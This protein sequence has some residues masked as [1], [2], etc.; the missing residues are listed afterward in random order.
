MIYTYR[1]R[2][3]QLPL[4]LKYG[5]GELTFQK[6]MLPPSRKSKAVELLKKY[7][8]DFI[9]VGTGTNRFIAKY[10][11]FAMKVAL[12]NDGI[13][14]NKQEYAISEQLNHIFPTSAADALELSN[15]GHILMSDYCPAFTSYQEMYD[16]HSRIEQILE[17]WSNAG[18]LLGDV[19]ISRINYANWGL[20]GDK[21]ICID[22][23]YVIP[24]SLYTFRCICGESDIA[25]TDNTF[26]AYK[27]LSCGRIIEDS[28]LRKRISPEIRMKMLENA[29]KGSIL[30]TGPTL[31]KEIPDDVI[32]KP[33]GPDDPDY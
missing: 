18:F 33:L 17:A 7:N 10:D 14:D 32:A 12:D 11:N 2:L 9:D 16:H 22:Y 28:L 24:A 5:L 20:K 19:G 3:N 1:S 26:T 13:A 23:A 4:D 29:T 31:D 8:V 30:M 15:G 27:C 6:G 25:I 21:A